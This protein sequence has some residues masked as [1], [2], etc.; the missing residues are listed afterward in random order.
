VSHKEWKAELA[1]ALR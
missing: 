1:C